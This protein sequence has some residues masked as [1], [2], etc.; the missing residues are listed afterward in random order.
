MTPD[1]S[2]RSATG[3]FILLYHALD[4][5]SEP[6]AVSSAADLS[7][8]VH[9]DQFAAQLRCLVE[10]GRQVVSLDHVLTSS[11]ALPAVPATAPVVLTFDDGHRSNWSLA[12]PRLLEAGAAA[13]FYVV[14]GFVDKLPDYLTSSQLRELAAAGMSV[15]SHGMSH[16]FLPQLAPKVVHLELADSRARLEDLLGRPVLDFALPGGHFDR[17][18]IEAI[19]ACGYRSVATCKVG[20][21]R[22]GGDP[23]RLPRL[24]IRRGLSPEGFRSTF[25]RSKVR[26]LQLLEA[27]KSCLRTTCGLS[28]YTGLRRLA[29]RCFR[30]H[31]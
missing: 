14:A 20:T 22:P 16:R 17:R 21:Y 31:R 6:A 24:E 10:M 28:V 19:R 18:V 25:T 26:Q 12:L 30:L 7:V 27:A 13:T 9:A 15:G 8:V 23:F 11:P 1:R 4:S 5:P 29:H 3:V 2:N